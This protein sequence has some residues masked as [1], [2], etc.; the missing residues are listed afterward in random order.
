[1]A[2]TLAFDSKLALYNLIRTA[3]AF[4]DCGVYYGYPPRTD[5]AERSLVWVGEIE[6][7]SEESVA[8][9]NLR[10]D[11]IF[12]IVV[13]IEEHWPGDSQIDANARAETHLQAL[14]ALIRPKN[15]LGISGPISVGLVPQLLGEGQD[16]QGRGALLVTVV[17]VHARK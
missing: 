15:A 3:P 9:G 12:R 8:M 1:M 13:T 2:G 11:E 16:T 7:E 6:W 17:R 14:E 4:V 5:E 10:R